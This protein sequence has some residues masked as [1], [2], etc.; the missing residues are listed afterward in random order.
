[1]TK[2]SY[3]NGGIDPRGENTF[4][5]RY[6]IGK[7]RYAVTFKGTRKE[8]N[9]KLRELLKSGDDGQ[10]VEPTRMTVGEWCEHW[11]SIGC[12]NRKKKRVGRKSSIRRVGKQAG[13]SDAELSPCRVCCLPQ[14]SGA[15]RSA[16]KQSD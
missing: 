10:H 11:L 3:G 14:R 4:R 7:Q 15:K 13:T 6:R 8:A 5:L 16:V 2:R 12:P 1:M 9:A